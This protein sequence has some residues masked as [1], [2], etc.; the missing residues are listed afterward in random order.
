MYSSVDPYVTT[1]FYTL[2]LREIRRAF[3]RLCLKHLQGELFTDGSVGISSHNSIPW[4]VALFSYRLATNQFVGEVGWF[5][6]PS[7]ITMKEIGN[8]SKS[9][10]LMKSKPRDLLHELRP[11]MCSGS[12]VDSTSRASSFLGISYQG[13]ETEGDGVGLHTNYVFQID[14]C[15]RISIIKRR[16]SQFLDLQTGVL[17]FFFQTIPCSTDLCRPCFSPTLFW[18]DFIFSSPERNSSL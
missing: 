5:G 4:R 10:L 6:S 2:F 7:V 1:S 9:S 3:R 12:K 11:M 13:W 16:F 17:S 18:R 14:Y 15:M 8:L